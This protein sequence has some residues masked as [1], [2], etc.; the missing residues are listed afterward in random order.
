MGDNRDVDDGGKRGCRW[1]SWMPI[2]D[3]KEAIIDAQEG[4]MSGRGNEAKKV[5]GIGQR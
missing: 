1:I 4:M 2:I 5:I 3:A